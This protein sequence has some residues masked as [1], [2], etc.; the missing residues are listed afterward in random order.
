M[1]WRESLEQLKSELARAR[2]SRMERLAAFDSEI[3]AER[4]Q[5]LSRYESLDIVNL[6]AQMNE[7]LLD[8]KG[9]VEHTVEWEE[10][11]DDDDIYGEDDVADVITT[12]LSW[13]EGEELEIIVELAMLDEGISLMVNGIQIRQDSSALERSL[14]EAFREQL[15]L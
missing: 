8:G 12:A 6:M 3:A 4:E 7:V 2:D 1:P 13:N 14:I 9:E 15:Q 10:D 11:G 5:L